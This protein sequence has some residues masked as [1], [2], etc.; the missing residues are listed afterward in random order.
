[1]AFRQDKELS[2]INA[3]VRLDCGNGADQFAVVGYDVR[4][5]LLPDLVMVIPLDILIPAKQKSYVLPFSLLLDLVAKFLVRF[6][7]GDECDQ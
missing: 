4:L 2:Y 3:S 5:L 1:M 6:I 7:S